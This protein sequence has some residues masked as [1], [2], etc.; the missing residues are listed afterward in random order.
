MS[1]HRRMCFRQYYYM[2]ENRLDADAETGGFA[3]MKEGRNLRDA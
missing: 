2:R 1:N 3:G